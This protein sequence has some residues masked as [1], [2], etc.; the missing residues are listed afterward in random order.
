MTYEVNSWVF[1]SEN[2]FHTGAY[3]DINGSFIPNNPKLYTAQMSIRGEC[4]IRLSYNHKIE[5]YLAIKSNIL[6]TNAKE[7]Y[8]S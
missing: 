1:K 5:Y 2:L 3:M 7:K 6:L 4:I 8:R